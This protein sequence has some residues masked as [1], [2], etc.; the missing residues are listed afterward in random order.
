MSIPLGGITLIVGAIV[1]ILTLAVGWRRPF[2]ALAALILGLPFRDFAS[3]W[4]NVHTDLTIEV[5]TAIGRWWIFLILALLLVWGVQWVL[6]ARATGLRL[7]LS[8]LDA[9]LGSSILIG[10]LYTLIAPHKLAAITSLRGYLQPLAVFVLARVFKPSRAELRTLLILL[11]ILGVAMAAFAIWQVTNW[12]EEDYRAQG[13]VRQNGELISPA[14]SLKGGDYIRPLS[15]VSGPNELGLDMVILAMLA[16]IW[17]LEARGGWRIPLLV[18]MFLFTVVLALSMSRSAFL[19]YVVALGVL[20]IG[21]WPRLRA[22]FQKERRARW[23][24]PLGVVLGLALVAGIFYQ[25]GFLKR[26]ERTLTRLTKQYHYVDSMEAF[27]FLMQ[28]PEGVGMGMVAPKGALIFQSID[29]AQHVEG[30][31]FQVAMEM[32]VWGL[33]IWLGFIALGLGIIYRNWRIVDA[34]LLRIITCMA[35]TV[36]LGALAALFFLPLMQSISLMCWLWFLLGI[37][38]EGGE[39][40]KAWQVQGGSMVSFPRR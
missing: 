34:P 28:N 29:A 39:I 17:L 19:A 8:W 25:T 26:V 15:L 18:L 5:V 32:G 1:I 24:I 13:Y 10:I 9:L 22:R 21:L 23:L 27:Q 11:L 3:R 33:A 38:V 4:L 14:I 20:E 31:L 2:T 35:Y 36:W 37:G 12:S 30:S 6:R 40:D 16:L 7:R